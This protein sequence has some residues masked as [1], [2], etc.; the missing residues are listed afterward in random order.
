MSQSLGQLQVIWGA[1]VGGVVL[2]T[3]LIF[4][5]MTAGVLDA[6]R[7]DPA[8]MPYAGGVVIVY[9]AAGLLVR[10]SMVA[11]IPSDADSETRLARYQTATIIPL[12]LMESGGLL[13]VTLG[14]LTGTATWVLAGGMA[15]ALLMFL[16][17]PTAAEVG[18]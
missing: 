2:Y 9:M 11:A 13:L 18:L 17:R 4:G 3:V 5:L 15:A 6:A 7:L 8:I 14:F 12:A 10:R 1:L 16:G